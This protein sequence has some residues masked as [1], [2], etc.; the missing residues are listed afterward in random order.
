MRIIERFGSSM[1]LWFTGLPFPAS[2]FFAWSASC[3]AASEWAMYELNAISA[4]RRRSTMA[5]W[6]SGTGAVLAAAFGLV[7]GVI[8]LRTT[9]ELLRQNTAYAG[10]Q[11]AIAWREQVLLLHDRGL[12]PDEIRYM[13]SCEDGWR[14]YEKS[15]GIID[16]IVR[17]VPRRGAQSPLA[18]PKERRG[19]KRP[20][21]EQRSD[22]RA[23][24]N[25]WYPILDDAE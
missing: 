6:L 25:E 15:N 19:V 14:G 22:P 18:R 24:P 9:K 5:D 7:F 21:G 11:S 3:E 2:G 4:R 1:K 8:S 13:M 16:E 17:N 20:G 10:A 23:K 12:S